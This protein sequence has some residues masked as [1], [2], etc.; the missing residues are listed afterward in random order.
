MGGGC[1]GVGRGNLSSVDQHSYRN[2]QNVMSV[3]EQTSTIIT[4]I[5]IYTKA[6]IHIYRAY[7]THKYTNK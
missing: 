6:Q 7:E 1:G 4:Y 5:H 2:K 3:V